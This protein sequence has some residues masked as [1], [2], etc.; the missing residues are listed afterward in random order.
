MMVWKSLIQVRMI[1]N[2]L[3]VSSASIGYIILIVCVVSLK[4]VSRDILRGGP[5][6]VRQLRHSYHKDSS[7]YNDHMIRMS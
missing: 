1:L 4:Y 2:K 7:F 3:K 6:S 5:K